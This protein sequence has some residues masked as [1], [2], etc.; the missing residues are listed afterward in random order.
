MEDFTVAIY[1]FIDDLLQKTMPKQHFNS[2]LSDSQ[3]IALLILSA[4]YF[5]GNQSAAADYLRCHHGFSIPDKS[6]LNRHIHRLADTMVDLFCTLGLIFKELNIES[7]YIIDSFPVSVCKNIRISRSKL[8]K[9]E[10]FRGYNASK[11][12][13]FFG[14]KVHVITTGDGIPVE[15]L[16]TPG[17]THDNA[18]FQIMPIDLPAKSHLYG[19]AAYLNAEDK[20]NLK[21]FQ[22]IWHKAATKKNSLEPNT[23]QQQLENKYF[24]KRI[25]NTFADINAKFPKKIHAV[26]AKGYLLKILVAIIAIALQIAFV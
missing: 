3:V 15:F 18:A 8:V 26:T 20:A 25:E 9:G 13:Y 7:T 1:C 6:N 22:D 17:R 21:E 12:E 16:V 14:F 19:D 2:K 23:W 10:E 5:Y 11:K 24:R 4:R